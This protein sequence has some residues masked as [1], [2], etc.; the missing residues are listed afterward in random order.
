MDNLVT[1]EAIKRGDTFEFTAFWDGAVASELTS[2]VRDSL[3]NLIAQVVIVAT[4]TPY[5][6]L[7]SVANTTAWPIGTLYV[8]IKRT[9]PGRIKTSDS[10]MAIRVIEGVTK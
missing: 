1:L 4:G 5:T 8:D 6:F 3:N 7:F 10:T 2:Q 9:T